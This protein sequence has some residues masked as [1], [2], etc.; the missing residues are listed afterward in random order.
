[1]YFLSSLTVPSTSL[2]SSFA[3]TAVNEDT[4]GVSTPGILSTAYKDKVVVAKSILSLSKG[5]KEK[6]YCMENVCHEV[7]MKR[8]RNT[9]LPAPVAKNLK[10]PNFKYS[11]IMVLCGDRDSGRSTRDKSVFVL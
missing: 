9:L 8:A 10:N 6:P 4:E 5:A 2:H 1:M 7:L 3:P 11:F